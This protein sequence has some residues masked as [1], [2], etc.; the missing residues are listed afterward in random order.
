MDRA[1]G[2]ED[3]NPRRRRRACRASQARSM[4]LSLQRARPQIVAPRTLR[5][6][7]RTASK[8]PGEA[9]GKAGL[10]DVDAQVDQRLGDL[11]LLVEVHAA[12]GRLLAVAE[13]GVE[14]DD[15]AWLVWWT[16]Q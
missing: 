10:D 14:D 2:Q 6:I 12:A 15:L 1:G 13:R 4:S 16:W 11:Q 9:I 8:S 3:V 5:A 7:S